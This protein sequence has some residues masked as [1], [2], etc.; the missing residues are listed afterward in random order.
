MKKET[1]QILSI[2]S[3]FTFLFLTLSANSF[4]A[5]NGYEASDQGDVNHLTLAQYYKH[6]A[7]EFQAKIEEEISAVKHKPR[8]S[9]LGRNAKQFKEHV[10]FKIHQYEMAVEE[11]LKKAAYHEKLAAEQ[12]FRPASASSRNSKS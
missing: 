2:I 12:T 5:D 8:T 7:D 1:A 3:L 10:E 6:Q 11:N 4:A 9:F